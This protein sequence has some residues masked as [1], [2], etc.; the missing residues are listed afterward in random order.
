[1]NEVVFKTLKEKDFILKNFLIKVGVEL[2]LTLND[3]LLLIYFMNQEEPT[4]NMQNITS[5]IYLNEEQVMESFNKLIGIKLIN[6][7]VEKDSRGVRTEI[8]N[9]DNIIKYATSDIT[10]KHKI[11]EKDNIFEKFEV[12]FGRTLSPIEYEIIN[13][14]INSGISKDL[15]IQALKESIYNGAK[16]LRYISKILMSWQEKGYKNKS[17]LNQGLKNELDNN[18]LTELF[19]YNWLDEE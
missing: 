12:E 15:I 3:M 2:N 7:K 5:S 18:V 16:S 9:L 14:W 6:M 8:I 10:K 1:M 4:L 17:D 11:E 19:D 13:D